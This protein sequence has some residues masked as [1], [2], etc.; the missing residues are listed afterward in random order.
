MTVTQSFTSLLTL[1]RNLRSSAKGKHLSPSLFA[2]HIGVNIMPRKVSIPQIQYEPLDDPQG[3]VD[4]LFDYLLKKLF[5][6]TNK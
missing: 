4:A 6:E 1:Q 5:D 2:L 3:N